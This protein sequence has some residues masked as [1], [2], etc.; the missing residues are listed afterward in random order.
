MDLG[1]NMCQKYSAIDTDCTEKE[2]GSTM[3][4]AALKSNKEKNPAKLL[5]MLSAFPS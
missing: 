2:C 3:K 1:F 5:A 4:L